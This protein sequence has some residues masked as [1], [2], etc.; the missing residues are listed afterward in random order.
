MSS[1]EEYYNCEY[2]E[3]GRLERHRIEYEIT[4]RVLKEYIKDGSEVLDVGGG[5]GKIQ[6]ISR[7][8]RPQG[9]T[10]GSVRKAGGTG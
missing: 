8:K 6:H 4:K 7:P 1:I 2:D 3:W 5:P 10:G 9:H